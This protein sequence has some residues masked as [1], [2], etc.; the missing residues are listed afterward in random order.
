MKQNIET[1]RPV[2]VTIQCTAYNQEPYIR[3]CLEGFLMQKTN[4]KFEV[5]VHDDAS[6]DR[7]AVIIKEYAEKYPEII[8]PI[9][10]TENQYS[11]HDGSLRHIMNEAS[12]GKYIAWCEGDDYWID[13]LKLQKQVDF[14]ENHPD[15]SLCGTNGLIL[16]ENQIQRPSYFN[17]ELQ[18]KEVSFKEVNSKWYFPTASLFCR[19]E[20]LDNY[21]EWTSKIYSGD[22]TLVLMAANIGKI[23]YIKDFTCIYRRGYKDSLSATVD[24]NKLFVLQQHRLLYAEFLGYSGEKFQSELK[25]IIEKF[26][27]EIKFRTVLSKNIL[28]AWMKYPFRLFKERIVRNFFYKFLGKEKTHLLFH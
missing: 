13:P 6:T 5:I 12:N 26:D 27:E 3:Q 18:S 19:K 24:K 14:M 23:Y 7:T 17:N 11:K 8:K 2:M 22:T 28:I 9:L 1:Q 15:F 25:T 21:P 20:V 4:F 16:W 10:E